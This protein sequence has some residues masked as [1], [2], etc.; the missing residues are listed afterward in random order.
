MVAIT[1]FVRVEEN[2]LLYG[3]REYRLTLANGRVVDLILHEQDWKKLE[4]ETISA[5]L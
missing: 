1:E 4:G 3:Q 5:H 2:K